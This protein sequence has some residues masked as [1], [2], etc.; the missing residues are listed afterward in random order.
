MAYTE[1]ARIVFSFD[2][3]HVDI[4]TEELL[5]VN[6]RTLVDNMLFT[7]NIGNGI[8]P[9][10]T[11][12][13]SK[14]S[15][16]KLLTQYEKNTPIATPHDR[17]LFLGRLL[18]LFLRYNTV[19]GDVRGYQMALP[20]SVFAY[21]QTIYHLQHECFASPMN[22]CPIIN[23]FCSRFP[24]TDVY[25]G[26]QGS[27]FDYS[28]EEGVFE[29]NPPF[30]EECIIRNIRRIN[31]LLRHADENQKP[32]TFFIIVPRWNEADCESYNLTVFGTP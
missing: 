18:L 20:E 10:D 12:K 15:Y 5:Q 25:F 23:S 27:F 1:N 21:L 28:I 8:R 14:D 26:S 2:S 17:E 30:V 7:Y 6:L 19:S 24:D 4:N 29:A 3:Y 32:L 22:A 11:I 16:Q 13:F 31:E 9:D